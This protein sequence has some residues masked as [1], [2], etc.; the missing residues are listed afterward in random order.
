MSSY[1]LS[2]SFPSISKHFELYN[3]FGVRQ[4]CFLWLIYYVLSFIVSMA[5]LGDV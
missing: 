1:Y 2:S 4:N 3:L 5:F